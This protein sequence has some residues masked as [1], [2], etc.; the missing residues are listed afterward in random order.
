MPERCTHAN[1]V[2]ATTMSEI[3][4]AFYD[5]ESIKN[6]IRDMQYGLTELDGKLHEIN[7]RLRSL[8]AV[9]EEICPLPGS[10]SPPED[11]HRSVPL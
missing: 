10:S 9:L 8:Q 1:L 7:Q 2:I 11:P 5:I 3:E 4:S 6:D